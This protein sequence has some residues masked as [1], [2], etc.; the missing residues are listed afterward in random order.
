MLSEK[1]RKKQEERLARGPARWVTQGRPRLGE[2]HKRARKAA[3]TA[4]RRAAKLQRT[5]AWA[6]NDAIKAVYAEARRLTRE[7]GV[8]HQVDHVVPLRGKLVS[9][10]HVQ[11]NLLVIPA[12]ENGRKFNRHLQDE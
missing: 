3:E 10:L 7:T 6:D 5:P 8:P 11:N 2:E 1:M 4:K 9:G 12:V